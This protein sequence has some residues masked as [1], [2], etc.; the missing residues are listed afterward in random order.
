VIVIAPWWHAWWARLAYILLGLFVIHLVF[1]SRTNKLKKRQEELVLEVRSATKEIR[2]QKEVVEVAHKE[3]TDSINYAKRLQDAILPT[4][5]TINE[6]IPNN[7]IYFNPKDVVSG[8][9]YWFEHFDGVSYIAAADCTG[10]G[11]PGAMVSV[12]CANALHRVVNEFGITEPSE[13]LDKT[14]ELV[15]ATFTRN[16]DNVK[17]GMDIALL[18][19]KKDKVI[20]SGAN[21]PLWVVRKS[22]FIT[23]KE[24]MDKG[25]VFNHDYSLIEFKGDKQPVGRYY[26]LNPF[27]QTEVEILEGDILYLFTDGFADQFGGEKG[28]KLKYRPF[29]KMLINSSQKTMS[30][31]NRDLSTNFDEWKSNFEQI[32]DVCVIGVKL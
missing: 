21:N 17:D 4:F 24:R 7:F 30:L 25:T 2:E 20:F 12:V 16:G 10:H 1:K 19:I 11:V 31:Q 13:I 29:K 15:I 27:T 18:A 22:E 5:E 8:D 28:K 14:R 6:F 26:E 3:I 9:F 23:E 32:D